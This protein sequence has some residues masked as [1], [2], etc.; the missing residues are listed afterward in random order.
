M[1]TGNLDFPKRPDKLRGTNRPLVNGY[2][3]PFPKL[4]RPRREGNHSHP[5]SAKVM[6]EGNNTSN[7]PAG[8]YGVQRETF[9]FTN[10]KIVKNLFSTFISTLKLKV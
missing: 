8:L 9:T 1:G 10:S 7:S 3:S 4:K 6:N 2:R 5:P